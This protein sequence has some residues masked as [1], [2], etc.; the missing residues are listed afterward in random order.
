MPD[1][2]TPGRRPRDRSF[3][4]LP[5]TATD[6]SAHSVGSVGS[7]GALPALDTRTIIVAL[8]CWNDVTSPAPIIIL[9][10]RTARRMYWPGGTPSIVKRPCE[11]VDPLSVSI[12]VADSSA[13]AFTS[14]TCRFVASP[15]GPIATPDTFD[16]GTPFN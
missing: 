1:I 2:F 6:I 13:S 3:T 10:V 9:G 11:S 16:A 5:P 15:S 12:P 4:S 7:G 8:P 14:V